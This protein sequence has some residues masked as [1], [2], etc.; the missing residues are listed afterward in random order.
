MCELDFTIDDLHESFLKMDGGKSPG[1]DGLGKEF[2]LQFWDKIGTLLHDSLIQG[3]ND[4][5][6]SPSQNQS[7][8]KLLAKKDRDKSYIENLRPI[9]LINCD[10]KGGSKTVASTLRKVL[11]SLI[12]SDQTAYVFGRFIG[13]SSRLISDIIEVTRNINIGGYLVTMDIK[14][15]FD[16]VNHDFLMLVLKNANFGPNFLKWIKVLI[17]NQ[18]SSVFNAGSSTGYFD[19]SRGCRQG[20]PISAYLFI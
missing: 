20:D 8:I 10:T 18:Q 4:G 6:F 5:V 12:S 7:I 13:E 1:N 19:L 16:S 14:K 3:K 17:S 2:Y 11:P 15:A 9:S